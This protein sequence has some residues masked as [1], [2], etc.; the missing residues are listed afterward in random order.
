MSVESELRWR[1]RR[2][3]RILA[4]LVVA[5]LALGVAIAGGVVSDGASGVLGL[6]VGAVPF[7]LRL[8]QPDPA[9]GPDETRDALA[10]GGVTTPPLMPPAVWTVIAVL[11]VASLAFA[12]FVLLSAD[13]KRQVESMAPFVVLLGAVAL[14]VER[15]RRRAQ[16]VL[17]GPR[18][19]V[20]P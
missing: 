2:E 7:V 11:F 9:D 17:A 18:L 5:A 10:A 13:E 8:G 12:F 20:A 16:D 3:Q 4:L 6:A 14:Q 15:V 1:L 19:G